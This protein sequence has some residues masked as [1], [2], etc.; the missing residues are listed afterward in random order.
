[1]AQLTWEDVYDKLR[2]LGYSVDAHFMNGD[3]W[4]VEL[5]KPS[6]DGK[7][8]NYELDCDKEDPSSIVR[9]F[10]NLSE[11]YDVDDEVAKW[12]G[13]DKHPLEAAGSF[14]EL[15]RDIEGIDSDLAKTTGELTSFVKYFNRNFSK[16]EIKEAFLSSLEANAQFWANKRYGTNAERLDNIDIPKRCLKAAAEN[17][18]YEYGGGSP[19]QK[20]KL[21]NE[22]LAEIGISDGK[23]ENLKNAFSKALKEKERLDKEKENKKTKEKIGPER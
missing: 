16:R 17:V 7:D 11:N 20:K 14:S 10:D 5:S 8:C 6:K 4:R 23:E 21:L 2:H 18:L 12:I 1:M 3:H 19:L 13:P 15:V 22:Y 9:E